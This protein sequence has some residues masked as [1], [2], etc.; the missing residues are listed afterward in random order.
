[1][2]KKPSGY[3][4]LNLEDLGSLTLGDT[5]T[6]TDKEIVSACKSGKP[7][8]CNWIVDDVTCTTLLSKEEDMLYGHT[9]TKYIQITINSDNVEIVSDEI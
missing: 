9:Q 8:L 1:M 7:V 5:N 2:I 4:I 6:I 3:Q